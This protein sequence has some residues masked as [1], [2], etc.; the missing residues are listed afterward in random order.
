MKTYTFCPVSDKKI[1]ERVARSNAVLTVATLVIFG[2][3]QNLLLLI[4]L[5]ADFLLRATK[6][7]KYSLFFVISRIIVKNLPVRKYKINAGPKIFAARVGLLLT[8]LILILFMLNFSSA[9]FILAG[10]LGLFS[11]LEGVFG[12]CVACIIYPFVFKWSYNTT[13]Y[14]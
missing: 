5:A 12:I 6:W 3:T 9:A 2:L 13:Y 10:I 7:S 1:N 11:L 8:S 14:R 4:F